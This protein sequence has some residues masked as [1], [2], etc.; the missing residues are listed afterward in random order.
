MNISRAGGRQFLFYPLVNQTEAPAGGGEL[1]GMAEPFRLAFPGTCPGAFRKRLKA[2][3]RFRLPLPDPAADAAAL[4]HR[5]GQIPRRRLQQADCRQQVGLA[6][7][8]GPNQHIE[9]LQLQRHSR[10]PE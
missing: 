2:R 4:A 8:V 5:P 6:A 3:R 10:R 1:D 9:R 7:A